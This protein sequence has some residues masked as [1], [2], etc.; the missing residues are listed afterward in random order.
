LDKIELRQK[1][2]IAKA[3]EKLEKIRRQKRKRSKRAKE[4]ILIAKHQQTEKKVLRGK[5][6]AEE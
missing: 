5:V 2:F 6:V 3:T 4:K 1:G